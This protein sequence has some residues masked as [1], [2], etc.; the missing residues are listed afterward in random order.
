MSAP[1]CKAA[2]PTLAR[3][4][5][6]AAGWVAPAAVLALLPK[7]P[8][9]VAAYVALGTGLGI[10]VSAASYLRATAI[11]LSVTSLLVLAA[12][13]VRRRRLARPAEHL[14]PKERPS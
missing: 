10:S 4:C 12:Q 5:A 9:C 8:A 13:T 3:R 2:R 11:A 6:G 1:C 14:P 7:C